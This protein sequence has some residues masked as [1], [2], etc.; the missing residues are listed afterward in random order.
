MMV[1]AFMPGDEQAVVGEAAT[2]QNASGVRDWVCA[3]CDD[4]R[5][6]ERDIKPA[7]SPGC[8]HDGQCGGG[9]KG[10]GSCRL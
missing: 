4:L 2:M 3:I 8:Q 1:G 10:S 7:P 6:A 5:F 9:Q